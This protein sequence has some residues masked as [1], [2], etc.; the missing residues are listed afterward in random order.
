MTQYIRVKLPDGTYGRMPANMTEEQRKQALAAYQS[1]QEPVIAAASKKPQSLPEMMKRYYV[2][3]PAASL[4]QFGSNLLNIPSKAAYLTGQQQAGDRL[5]YKPNFDYRKA[6]GIE[7]PEN[8]GSMAIGL[9]PEILAAIAM[10]GM[11]LG[12]LGEAVGRIPKGGKILQKMLSESIP[13][14]GLAAVMSDPSKMAESAAIAGGTQGAFTGL[15]Q[16]ALSPKPKVQ[17][18]FSN[19]LGMGAGGLT[20]YGLSEAGANPAITGLGGIAAGALARKPVGTKAMM[21]DDLASGKNLPKAEERLKMAQRLNLDFLTPEEAFN[22]PFLAR[23]QGRLGRT[24]EGSELM[25]DKFQKRVDSEQKAINRVLKQIHDPDIM[26]PK[27]TALYKEAYKAPVPYDVMA[28]LAE[29]KIIHEAIKKVESTPAYKESLK[30]VS[31]DSVEYLDHVK[32]ALDDMIEAAPAKEAAII[33]KTKNDMLS[34]LD[35]ISPA[36]KEARALEERKFTRRGLEDAFDKTNIRSGH[37]FYKALNSTEDFNKLMHN[38]RNVPV[39]RAKLKYMRELFKDFRKESTINKVR[40]LEQ[41]GMKQNR[42]DINAAIEMLGN[43][44]TEGKFDKEAIEFITSKD[45]NKQLADINKI[46]DKQKRMAKTIEVF[47]KIAAQSNAN[48]KAPKNLD[49]AA[50]NEP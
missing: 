31:I 15:G 35:D 9:A 20:A 42:N 37:A 25:Y 4:G 23:K 3:E 43:M 39:A 24:D 13:Q 36:Y 5:S 40:G 22:S 33:R 47:G 49:E 28:S 21:M 46:T 38:L 30:N 41:V 45:W 16:L 27:A 48:K 18:L 32:Q 12:K 34:Q 8:L 7:E 6:V 2:Q 26:G 17:K 11:R 44:F 50:T 10:P 14:A 1:R 29:N 19:L